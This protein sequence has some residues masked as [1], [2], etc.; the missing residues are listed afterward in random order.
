M[1][2][3]F[4]FRRRPIRGDESLVLADLLGAAWGPQEAR[5]RAIGLPRSTYQGIERRLYENGVIQ[6]RY[7]PSPRALGAT[8]V[9]FLLSRPFAEGLSEERRRLLEDPSV[10]LLWGGATTNFS[11]RFNYPG[12]PASDA[13]AKDKSSQAEG[14][15]WELTIDP[16]LASVPAYFDFEG[17]MAHILG[18]PTSPRYPRPLPW[19]TLPEGPHPGE[20]SRYNE[21]LNRLLRF[22]DLGSEI[23]GRI[24]PP[25]PHSLPRSQRRL[26]EMGVVDWRICPD[27]SRLPKVG[28]VEVAHVVYI[29]GTLRAG[30]SLDHVFT[31]LVR[32]GRA[33][34]VL[35]TS[36]GEHVFLIALASRSDLGSGAASSRAEGALEVLNKT[37][38]RI[39]VLRE[40]TISLR[41]CVSHRYRPAAKI[42][43][44]S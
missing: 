28:E 43:S 24:H 26:L 11:V 16:G 31:G 4:P 10:V 29:H 38:H 35:L 2:G 34:P 7:V 23:S 14:S 18:R 20:P 36:D 19:G 8:S 9:T 40:E 13:S 32:D 21:P 15:R 1:G 17:A 37:L 42:T 5:I 12:T 44:T 30:T 25:R 3:L 22:S 27:V 39:A 41:T 6:D 33:F